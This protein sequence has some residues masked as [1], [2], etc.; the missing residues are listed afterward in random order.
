LRGMKQSLSADRYAHLQALS[1]QFPSAEDAIAEIAALEASLTLPMGVVHVISDIHGEDAKL[2]HVINNASGRLRQLVEQVVGP[3]MSAEELHQF[4]AVLYYPREAINRF[5]REV[6]ASGARLEWVQRTLTLQFDVVREL[7]GTYR[8]EHFEELLPKWYRELFIELGS[9]QRPAYIREMIAAL[10]KYDRDWGAVRAGARLIR[11][12]SCDEL[13]VLGDLGDRGPRI[14]RVIETLMRQ[15]KCNVIW[16]NHDMLWIGSHLGHEPC[17]LTALRFSLRYRRLSQLEEGYGIIMAPIERLVRDVYGNDPAEKWAAKGEGFRDALTVARMQKAVAIMQF[18]AE[19]RMFERHPE[20][21]LSHRRLLHAIDHAKKTV[22]ID[23]VEHPLLDSLLPTIDPKD[24]Y[25][26]SAEEQACIDRMRE[27]F[28]RSMKLRE[29]MEWLVNRGGM[30]TRRDDVLFFH[31][32]VPVDGAGKLQTLKVEGREAGGVELMNVLE[33]ALRRALRKKWVGLDGDADLIWYLWGGPKSPLFGK[34]KLATFETHF[35]ADKNA[36][37]EHKNAYFDLIHDAS[38]IQAIGREF[39]M[40]EDVLVV[41]GHVPVKIEKGE[42]PVKKG[43]NAI[44]IDGAFSEAYGDRGYTLVLKPDRIDLAEHAT[45]PGVESVL[46]TGS[47][48]VPTVT[49]IRKYA[50]S[51]TVRETGTGQRLERMISDLDALVHAYQEGIVRE[52]D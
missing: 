23:G 7:R 19:G 18:K 25:A 4:L 45:F 48:I 26:Y 51:R 37:K 52:R 8:R 12:L 21:N 33:S 17:M 9:G 28:T 47:D 1:A 3:K 32:C 27:S 36:H 11:N 50:R 29:H 6:V 46:V 5:S 43:G 16:G 41:N 13:L 20:W 24:P 34:D 40:G 15:P 42:A 31:A 10:A 35:V 30:W 22:T 2:R 38:F 49:T 39:G 44:T 14:D